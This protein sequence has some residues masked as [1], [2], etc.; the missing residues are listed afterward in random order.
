[1]YTIISDLLSRYPVIPA[2]IISA[3]WCYAG[4]RY[5]GERKVVGAFLWS[6]VGVAFLIALYVNLVLSGN[7]SWVNLVV[8]VLAIGVEIWIIKNWWRR[9]NTQQLMDVNRR[10]GPSRWLIRIWAGGW[11]PL[12]NLGC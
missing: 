9:E 11:L 7:N 3:V 5:L 6:G 4:Y 2:L 1:M 12:Q 8:A 10:R